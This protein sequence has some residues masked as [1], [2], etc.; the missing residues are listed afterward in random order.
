M[1]T[2]A[3]AD[4][5]WS[6]AARTDADLFGADEPARALP[7]SW[8]GPAPRPPAGRPGGRAEATDAFVRRHRPVAGPAR[9]PSAAT[10]DSA[11]RRHSRRPG[12]PLRRRRATGC[13]SSPAARRQRPD[14]P[15]G[16]TPC[17]R[18][19]ERGDP[20]YLPYVPRL[21]DDVPAPRR[22]DRRRTA[23]NVLATAP[24]LHSLA[25][26]RARVPGRARPARRGLDVAAAAGRARPGPP[27]RRR[28]RRGPARARA[29]RAGR[30]RRG[31]GRLVLLAPRRRRRPDPGD[32][33]R[34]PRLVPAGG[35]RAASPPARAPTST[36][37]PGCMTCADGRPRRPRALRRLR[38][39][40]RLRAPGRPA[41]RRLAAARANSTRCWTGSTARAPSDRSPSPRKG[42]CHGK[43]NLVHRRLRR[44]RP[45]PRG[46]RRERLRLQRQRRAH[47]APR[48]RPARRRDAGEPRLRRAP[49]V[50]W[51]SPCSS[52]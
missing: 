17:A 50:D 18:I 46:H 1:T 32:R 49:R 6:T 42:D 8:P 2:T 16:D 27:R 28:A 25:E 44:R 30:A 20:R 41:R 23:V 24:G 40:C 7:A 10:T 37:P 3:D 29:D 47:R 52:T 11:R 22:R 51:P 45:L 14:G 26:V 43:W 4:P 38:R 5:R 33:A 39:G 35:R 19:A 13:S 36:W 21:V 48:A 9:S 12:R 31:A 34:L 15:R